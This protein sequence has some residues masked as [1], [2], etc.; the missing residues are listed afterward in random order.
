MQCFQLM[1]LRCFLIASEN[2]LNNVEVFPSR[3]YPYVKGGRVARRVDNQGEDSISQS[4]S[5]P[6]W[7]RAE[8]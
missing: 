8:G 3:A 6:G 5:T 2:R 4:E 1:I 7:K